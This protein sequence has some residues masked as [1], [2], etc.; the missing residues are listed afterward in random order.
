[1]AIVSPITFV[2]SIIKKSNLLITKKK[3]KV[4][5]SYLRYRAVKDVDFDLV[6]SFFGTVGNNYL[7]IKELYP[8][9]KYLTYFVGFDYSSQIYRTHDVNFYKDLFKYAD[10]ICAKSNFSKQTLIGL[11]CSEEKLILDYN[12][13]DTTKFSV[14]TFEEPPYKTI[15]LIIVSR[16][17]KKKCHLLILQ[18]LQNILKEHKNFKF[19]IVGDG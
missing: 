1:D 8:Q 9:T 3:S 19:T 16:L 10:Y 14:K 15:K 5:T 17:E 11:G 7:F 6:I 2:K 13:I 12:G 18:A 4:L